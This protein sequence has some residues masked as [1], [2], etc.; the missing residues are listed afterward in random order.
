MK[1]LKSNVK[2]NTHN[3]FGKPNLERTRLEETF[4]HFLLHF[5]K[6]WA[7]RMKKVK[8]CGLCCS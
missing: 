7:W 3:S 5:I 4:L 2:S 8:V 6:R 1:K